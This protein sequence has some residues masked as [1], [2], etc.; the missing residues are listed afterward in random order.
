MI[1]H[2]CSNCYEVDK[3]FIYSDDGYKLCLDCGGKVL[4][5]QEAADTIGDLHSQLRNNDAFNEDSE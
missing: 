2:L 3:G 1:P 5:L 4:T